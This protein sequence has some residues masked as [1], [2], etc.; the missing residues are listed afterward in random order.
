MPHN[1]VAVSR[2]IEDDAERTRLGELAAQI[3]AGE[4]GD[5]IDVEGMDGPAGWVI[6]TA[7]VGMQ[8]WRFGRRHGPLSPP[9]WE[10]LIDRAEDA[11]PATP[12][13]RRPRACGTRR[14]RPCAQRQPQP[15]ALKAMARSPPRKIIATHIRPHLVSA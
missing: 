9:Q 5:P 15:C 2:S 1:R 13:S 8:G 11:T 6:R 3:I 7:A 10:V 4:H 12:A 14:A